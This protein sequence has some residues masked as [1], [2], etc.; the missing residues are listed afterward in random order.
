MSLFNFITSSPKWS[1]SLQPSG[2]SIFHRRRKTDAA[3]MDRLIVL[4]RL[5][6]IL[7]K[8]TFMSASAVSAAHWCQGTR[9]S[10]ARLSFVTEPKQ[11]ALLFSPFFC[12][13]VHLCIF[14][15]I[16][17]CADRS[18]WIELYRLDKYILIGM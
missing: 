10:A 1:E 5:K 4:P 15:T 2:V 11:R 8:S 14:I 17:Y 13:A 6:F 16:N 12:R 7:T 18:P 9:L 3:K